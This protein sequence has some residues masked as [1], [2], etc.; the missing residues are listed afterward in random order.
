[1]RWVAL[2]FPVAVLLVRTVRHGRW[3]VP[4]ARRVRWAAPLFPAVV[5]RV[6]TGWTVRHGR[7]VA[8][9]SLVAGLRA[10]MV[11]PGRW[12]AR[13]C[14]FVDPTARTAGVVVDLTDLTAGVV[15]GRTAGVVPATASGLAGRAWVLVGRVP[16]VVARLCRV[17]VGRLPTVDPRWARSPARWVP[18]RSA[19]LHPGVRRWDRPAPGRSHRERP[20]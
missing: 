14:P 1:V 19:P 16:P 2:L 5:L 10:R 3:P 8:L 15:A 9:L 13:P 7:W 11:R 20:A 4:T 18:H 17:V 6:R 12:V